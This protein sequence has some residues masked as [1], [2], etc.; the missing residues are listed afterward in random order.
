MLSF[1]LVPLGLPGCFGPDYNKIANE[2]RAQ[3]LKQN[4]EIAT[5]KEDL[6]NRDATIEAMR[7]RQGPA[8]ETLPRERL[9]QL[10]TVSR[11]EIRSTSD[12]Y[13]DGDGKGTNAFRVYIRLHD[14]DGQIIPATGTM[15]IE[16][17]ELPPAPA[18]PRRIGS[19]T[20]TPT[21]MKKS[22]YSGLGL[23]H[24]AF[25]CPWESPPTQTSV[26]FKAHYLD[27]LTGATLTAQLERKIKLPP[28]T[29]SAP[30]T[31]GNQ[32]DR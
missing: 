30:K 15:T 23:N 32:A 8:L 27:L 7:N 1:C 29:Q 17:F 18:Q 2:L 3:T 24:F 6:K 25:A 31:T 12:T 16:A 9:E 22:W 11:M 26:T 20:F 13:D 21:Q 14:S 4:R 28:G 10:F 5:L 19:W